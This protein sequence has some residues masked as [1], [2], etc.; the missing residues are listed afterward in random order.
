MADFNIISKES[1]NHTNSWKTHFLVI[2][3]KCTKMN[4]LSFGKLYY[5]CINFK[6]IRLIC[7][8][9]QNFSLNLQLLPAWGD[10]YMF[11]ESF[12][13]ARQWSLEP[14]NW[15]SWAERRTFHLDVY[16]DAVPF[17]GC[18]VCIYIPM[19]WAVFSFSNLQVIP[20]PTDRECQ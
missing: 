18:N 10:I 2:F 8:F 15:V 5:F 4:Q 1:C 20:E 19:M 7:A 9:F 17:P 14:L 12:S 13:S 16:T 6:K 3:W 11:E